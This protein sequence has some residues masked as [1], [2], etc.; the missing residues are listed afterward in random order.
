MVFNKTISAFQRLFSDCDLGEE[1]MTTVIIVAETDDSN[2]F[3]RF[4]E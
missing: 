1:F 2:W 4:D 3:A